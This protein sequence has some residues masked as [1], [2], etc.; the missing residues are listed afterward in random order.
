MMSN[1]SHIRQSK[2]LSLILRH[3]PGKIGLSLDAGGWADI[4][5]LLAKSADYGVL[6]SRDELEVVVAHND[7]QRFIIS[8]D[9]NRIRANQ[10]HSIAIDLGLTPLVPPRFLYHG[11]AVHFLGSILEHG[12]KK[13]KRHHVHLSGDKQTAMK[14]GQRHGE[15]VVLKILAGQMHQNGCIFFQS[16]NG[17]WL[18]DHVPPLYL[19]L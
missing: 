19:L 13:Q 18:T 8:A 11:T 1:R 10:G 5:E 16:E 4:A 6:I 7:K 9:G 15:P 2:F 12:L 3:Q 14:V 17:V